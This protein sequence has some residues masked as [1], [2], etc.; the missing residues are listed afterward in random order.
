M[1][2]HLEITLDDGTTYIEEVIGQRGSMHD[3]FTTN[4]VESKFRHL[5]QTCLEP[6][7]VDDIISAVNNLESTTNPLLNTLRAIPIVPTWP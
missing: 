3:P 6:S 1:A 7:L 2:G 5:T 4:E